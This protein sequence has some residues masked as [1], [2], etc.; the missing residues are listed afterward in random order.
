M[1]YN[2]LQLTGSGGVAPCPSD[3][4]DCQNIPCVP[5]ASWFRNCINDG[6]CPQLMGIKSWTSLKS[7]I[8]NKPQEKQNPFSN[9]ATKVLDQSVFQGSLMKGLFSARGFCEP[10]SQPH[11]PRPPTKLIKNQVFHTTHWKS[12]PERPGSWNFQTGPWKIIRHQSGINFLTLYS[13]SIMWT[14]LSIFLISC[15]DIKNRD[16]GNKL[17]GIYCTFWIYFCHTVQKTFYEGRICFPRGQILPLL[18]SV[19]ELQPAKIFS[20][21]CSPCKTIFA[22]SFTIKVQLECDF[23]SPFTFENKWHACSWS[24]FI[25]CQSY[26]MWS[27]PVWINNQRQNKKHLN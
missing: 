5:L 9:M 3:S 13:T 8:H 12:S 25:P 19:P 20:R 27:L 22:L 11:P 1:A 21:K 23:F 6:F 4:S 16:M 26:S 18:S 15:G 14:G 2:Q 17:Q 24:W 10:W 7:S